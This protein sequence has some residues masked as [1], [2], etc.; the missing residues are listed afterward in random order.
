MMLNEAKVSL[1]GIS[2]VGESTAHL[3][4]ACG[5]PSPVIYSGNRRPRHRVGTTLTAAPYPAQ[6]TPKISLFPGRRYQKR[7]IS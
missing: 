4:V 3:A 6:G 7:A 1:L 2:D 5:R